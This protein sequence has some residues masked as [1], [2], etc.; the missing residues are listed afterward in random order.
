[1]D[2]KHPLELIGESFQTI[3]DHL[4]RTELVVREKE[5]YPLILKASQITNRALIIL[6]KQP[7]GK[8][9]KIVDKPEPVIEK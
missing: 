8:I 1:M 3:I 7:N 6:L 9:E 5:V 2:I 4:D